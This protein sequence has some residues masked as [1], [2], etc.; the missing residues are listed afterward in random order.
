MWG[1]SLEGKGGGAYRQYLA[2][3][4]R[5]G[6]RAR[7]MAGLARGFALLFPWPCPQA[8]LHLFTCLAPNNA[9]ACRI[10]Q[11]VSYANP[12]SRLSP[13]PQALLDLY[14]IKREIGRL[15]DIKVGWGWGG[16]IG[17]LTA[18]RQL[19]T[20]GWGGV[21]WEGAACCAGPAV[22]RLGGWGT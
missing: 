15:E 1:S 20:V 4:T 12:I 18:K 3:G 22:L 10:P 6:G 11:K 2:W 9:M 16:G 14:T 17:G 13:A 8:L 19:E 7:S 5:V 21:R